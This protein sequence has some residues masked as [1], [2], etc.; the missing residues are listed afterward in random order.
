MHQLWN[1]KQITMFNLTGDSARVKIRF[2]KQFCFWNNC[3]VKWNHFNKLETT[4]CCGKVKRFEDFMD[5]SKEQVAAVLQAW[6]ELDV[7]CGI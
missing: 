6:E 7:L 3:T 2:L 4:T 1:F 5:L